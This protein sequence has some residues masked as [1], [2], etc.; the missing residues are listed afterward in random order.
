MHNDA[1]LTLPT[2]TRVPWNKDKLIGAKPPVAFG[3]QT[4]IRHTR[5]ARTAKRDRKGAGPLSSSADS[6]NCRRSDRI[7]RLS[8]IGPKQTWVSALHMSAFGGKPDI[9]LG[10]FYEHA[11]SDLRVHETARHLLSGFLPAKQQFV[12]R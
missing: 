7:G 6:A 5:C 3:E 1:N 10:E 4:P 8:A 12:L 2:S 11:P 9:V